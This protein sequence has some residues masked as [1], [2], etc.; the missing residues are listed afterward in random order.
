VTCNYREASAVTES[1]CETRKQQYSPYRSTDSSQLPPT[2]A[3]WSKQL[4]IYRTPVRRVDGVHQD[5]VGRLAGAFMT[6]F[7]IRH[8]RWSTVVGPCRRRRPVTYLIA[9]PAGNWQG[10][11]ANGTLHRTAPII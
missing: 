8:S 5:F 1:E 4:D 9:R 10:V 3:R 2:N 7:P 11:P 6:A